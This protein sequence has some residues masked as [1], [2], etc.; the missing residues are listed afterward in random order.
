MNWAMSRPVSSEMST[1][2]ME[3]V[4]PLLRHVAL[5]INLS[6]FGAER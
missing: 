4:R 6:P 2:T 5:A 3:D 1:L